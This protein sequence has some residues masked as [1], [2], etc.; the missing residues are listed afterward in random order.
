M[1]PIVIAVALGFFLFNECR[2]LCFKRHALALA[3]IPVA[4]SVAA[5]CL[6]LGGWF[7][8]Y[9]AINGNS[10]DLVPYGV[11]ISAYLMARR[12]VGYYAE[13]RVE[14]DAAA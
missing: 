13:V 12:K 8:V 4:V 10:I 14:G 11:T 9:L 3:A 2:T 6:S 1:F 7:T 5:V